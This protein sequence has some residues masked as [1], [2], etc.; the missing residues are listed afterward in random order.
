MSVRSVELSID[1]VFRSMTRTKGDQTKLDH[2][3]GLMV[4]GG[5]CAVTNS[6][7]NS[8]SVGEKVETTLKLYMGDC[9]K[10]YE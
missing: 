8:T 5:I 6:E 10:R 7:G 4:F 2:G 1:L 9:C 3:V